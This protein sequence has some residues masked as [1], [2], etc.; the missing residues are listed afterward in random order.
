MSH[1]ENDEFIAKIPISVVVIEKDEEANLPRCLSSLQVFDQLVVIDDGSSDRSVAIAESYGAKVIREKLTTFAELQNWAHEHAGLKHDWVL[2]IYADEVVPPEL[3]TALQM[4]IANTDAAGFLLCCKLIFFEKWVRYS[5]SFPAWMPK[6]I[7]RKRAR[8]EVSGHTY[9]FGDA[10]GPIKKV[11]EPFLHYNFSKGFIDWWERHNRYSTDEA[12]ETLRKLGQSHLDLPGLVS[13]DG[14]RRRQALR[15]VARRMP[16][17]LKPMAKF[18][19]LYFIRLG[20][21]DGGPGLTFCVLQA[22]AEYMS[23]LKI[24]EELM[25]RKGKT[26]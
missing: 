18:F 20:I 23:T 10:K 16:L 4:A 1:L 9:Q 2:W 6:L 19:Y 14:Y 17:S 11:S 22:I 15:L 8:F 3:A 5:S 7:N 12:K 21:L 26:I 13:L 25:R 24:R